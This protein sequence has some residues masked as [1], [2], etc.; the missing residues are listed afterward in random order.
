MIGAEERQRS[1]EHETEQWEQWER[2]HPPGSGS[3][4]GMRYARDV[5]E[6]HQPFRRLTF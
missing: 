4:E 3:G 5:L 6:K 1:V 2:P